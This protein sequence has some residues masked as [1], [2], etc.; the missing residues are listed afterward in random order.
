RE[1]L[2]ERLPVRWD[3]V[4]QCDQVRRAD[5]GD[6]RGIEIR[7]ESQ[8]RQRGVAAVG[9]AQ[10]AD[11]PRVDDAFRDQVLDTPGE[12]VLHLL[13]PLAVAG[14]EETLAITGRST[15]VRLQNGVAAVGQE[16]RQAAVTPDVASPG[17]A[18]REDDERQ[19]L[20]G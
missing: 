20:G 14:V 9:T 5:D 3:R 16:L 15:E 17:T 4:E 6:A 19:V 11:A 8:A 18:V 7:R 1:D 10:D 13:T 2:A 12:V